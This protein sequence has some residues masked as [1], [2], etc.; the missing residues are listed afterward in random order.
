M[1]NL[2][3]QVIS[4]DALGS[5]RKEQYQYEITDAVID[6]ETG[7]LTITLRLNFVMPVIDMEKLSGILLNQ[8]SDLKS[9]EFRYE[10]ENVI[11]QKEEI[12]PLFIPHMIQII[13]GKYASITKTIE[14]KK[15]ELNEEKLVIY[16]LG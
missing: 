14:P 8:F 12:S 9:V 13:N 5:Y 15:F 11:Q 3:D 2:I 4:W 16:A 7:V 6:S 1:R 10:F